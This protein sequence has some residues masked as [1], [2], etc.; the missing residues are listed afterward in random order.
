V[1]YVI[2]ASVSE[3]AD[4]CVRELK[5]Q[6]FQVSQISEA[7]IVGALKAMALAGG[8]ADAVIVRARLHHFAD[9]ADPASVS[10]SRDI[11]RIDERLAFRGGVRVC[12]VPIVFVDL[13]SPDET[14]TLV[15]V[16]LEVDA[17]PWTTWRTGFGQQHPV[18][19]AIIKW[20]Q[21]LLN[22]LEYVGYSVSLD[23]QG[24][25]T[26]QHAM[27]RPGRESEILADEATPSGLRQSQ[28][29]ILA[30]DLINS[31][32][33]YDELR[34]L[35]DNY[36]HI[37]RKEKIK[38]E[39]VFQRFF[40]RN[41]HLILREMFSQWWSKPTLRLPEK[42]GHFYQP[43]FVLRPHVAA[44]LGTKWEVLDL[45]LPKD[46]LLTTG[47]FHP[48]FS[49]KL[50]KAIQQ[51]RDYRD[52]FSRPDTREQLVERFGYAPSH[53]RLAVLIG[54]NERTEGLERAHGSAALDVEIITYDEVVEFEQNR[55]A[56]QAQFTGL[57]TK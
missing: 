29:L 47:S 51:L 38:P 19:E 3:A 17:I 23:A 43:D 30:D 11:R 35:I 20:R 50:T 31:F 6:G 1:F 26:V 12:A 28:Y 52:Y 54:R 34:F 14:R 2:V 22:E 24:R 41:P 32:G 36:E 57:F 18:V 42:E 46:P 4:A 10:I 55:L 48:A 37:A 5:Q 53:P 45:K 44:S 33:V 21:A 7:S 49:Q 9:T 25:P 16:P 15:P 40:E 39:S 56:L 13:L 8:R 27:R